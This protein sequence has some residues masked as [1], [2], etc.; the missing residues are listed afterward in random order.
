MDGLALATV[1]TSNAKKFID[2]WTYPILLIRSSKDR[3]PYE[4]SVF[5]TP[6]PG[7]SSQDTSQSSQDENSFENYIDPETILLPLC[8][9]NR[10]AFSHMITFG[11][12]ANNDVC[13]AD[14]TLSKLHGWFLVPTEDNRAWRYVDNSS[15]NGTILNRH[16]L[17]AQR[18]TH[19]QFG[20]ELVV[21]QVNM[22]FLS[23]DSIL[24]LMEY[25]QNE[26]QKTKKVRR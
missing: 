24:D 26:N 22:L 25:M 21:G 18:A 8:K 23:R 10:N 7:L 1:F 11:R 14:A 4:R 6:D 3:A 13:L 2:G 17:L 12:A 20:D 19:L 5:D 9:S 15:T 16:K